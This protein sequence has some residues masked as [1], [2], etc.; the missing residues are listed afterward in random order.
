[1]FQSSPFWILDICILG[2]SP[3]SHSR[4]Y[5]LAM[6]LPCRQQ[7]APGGQNVIGGPWAFKSGSWLILCTLS[8]RIYVCVCIYGLCWSRNSREFAHRV[9][10]F[11]ANSEWQCWSH[12]SIGLYG[13]KTKFSLPF[14][15]Y[16]S[17]LQ[18]VSEKKFSFS[19]KS[20]V[21]SLIFYLEVPSMSKGRE[22]TF[23]P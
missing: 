22:T 10:V 18:T 8:P 21:M 9:S 17:N 14:I 15:K 13:T 11:T 6:L 7:A 2:D 1:M 12:Y 20:P 3:T 23:P 16:C 5:Q 19:P 4:S